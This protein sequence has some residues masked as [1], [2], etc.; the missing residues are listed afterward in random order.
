MNAA[1]RWGILA[2][3]VVLSVALSLAF[4]GLFLFFF[5]PFLFLPALGPRPV[6]VCPR[7]GQESSHPA[8]RYCP[9]DG[10]RLERKS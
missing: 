7:C 2:A 8:I 10:T 3:G 5:L 1:T 9:F 4:N 6:H